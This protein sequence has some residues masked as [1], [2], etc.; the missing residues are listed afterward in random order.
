M[1]VK[2]KFKE[3]EIFD[4]ASSISSDTDSYFDMFEEVIDDVVHQEVVYK[5]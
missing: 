1:K 4:N 2:K 5:K 3:D